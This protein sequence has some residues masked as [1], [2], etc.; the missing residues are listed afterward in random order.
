MPIAA[1]A[2]PAVIGAAGS[3]IG[4]NKSASAAKDAAN[5]QAS[6]NTQA[7]QAQK[8]MFN[9]EVNLSAPFRQLGT[10]ASGALSDIIN[11]NG[12]T[13]FE[14]NPGFKFATQ[15]GQQAIKRQA[16][17][18]GNL[19]STNTLANLG[20]YT[21]GAASQNYN[22]YVQQLLSAA[23]IGSSSS[24]ALDYGGALISQGISNAFTNTGQAKASAAISQAAPAQS[25]GNSLMG[26]AGNSNFINSL[27]S[28]FGGGGVAPSSLGIN[29]ATIGYG[30]SGPALPEI[31]N[32]STSSI[33][34]VIAGL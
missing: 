27:Q 24:S 2:I 6:A 32:Q 20:N 30:Q 25:V 8:D 12:T 19:Y 29:P 7:I 26:L 22:N 1:V 31:T 15:L 10:T 17:A 16:A 34:S 5:A 33:P 11:G 4:A 21:A 14:N 9:Q 28:A 3:I 23:G 13:A 18:G